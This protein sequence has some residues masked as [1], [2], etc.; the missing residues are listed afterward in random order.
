M[1]TCSVVPRGVTLYIFG[2][3]CAARTLKPLPYT[4]PRSADFATLD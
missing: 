2:R 3:G 1:E 4:K